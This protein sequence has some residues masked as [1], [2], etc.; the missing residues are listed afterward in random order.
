M[1]KIFVGFSGSSLIGSLFIKEI[2]KR[3][4]SHVYLRYQHPVTKE[5]I[6]THAAHGMVHEVS[7]DNFKSVND[8]IKEYEITLTNEQWYSFH[9]LNNHYKSSKYSVFQ[10]III[11]IKKLSK[12]SDINI[13]KNKQ[14]ICS[15]WVYVLL[16]KLDII[17]EYSFS[18]DSVTPSDLEQ[19]LIVQKT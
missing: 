11:A 15:E 4:Y 7:F 16:T 10:F 6:V 14:F 5:W 1:S 17:V 2:E 8:I 18:Q 3:P 9:K 13:N 19:M 12:R